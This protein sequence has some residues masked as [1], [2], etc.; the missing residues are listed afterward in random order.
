MINGKLIKRKENEMRKRKKCKK[1]NNFE[2]HRDGSTEG[3]QTYED[4]NAHIYFVQTFNVYIY[5][6]YVL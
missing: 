4:Y 1:K 5:D 3:N 2:R 6:M